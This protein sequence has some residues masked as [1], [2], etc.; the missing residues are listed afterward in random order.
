MSTDRESDI[1]DDSEAP[2]EHETEQAEDGAHPAGVYRIISIMGALALCALVPYVAPGL[3]RFR[4]WQ[5]GEEL[6]FTG[7]FSFEMP[8]AR[9]AIGGG[10][11]EVEAA[12]RSDDD[13]LSAA[14]LPE[15]MAPHG[16]GGASGDAG[17]T[18]A[19]RG[20]PAPRVPPAELQGLTREIELPAGGELDFFFERLAAA[21]RREPGAVAR[22]S[23]YAVSTNGADRVSSTIRQGLQEL[24][25]DAG[26][27]WIPIS[28][29]WT[30]QAHR[31]V[32][33]AYQSWRTAVVNRGRGPDGRYGLG[34]VIASSAGPHSWA[35]FGTMDDGPSNRAVSSFD[36]YYQSWPRGGEMVLEVDGAE[37]ERVNV[38][39]GEDT[40]D[41]VHEVRVPRGPH[42]L[43]IRVDGNVRLYG[44]TMENDGPGVVVDALMLIGASVSAAR[45]FDEEHI[46]TQVR[47]REPDLLVFWLGGND[48]ISRFFTP[49]RFRADYDD[50]IRR[51]RAGRPEASCLVVSVLDMGDLIDGRIRTRA[52]VEPVVRTQE[53]VARDQGCAF[54]NLYAATGGRGTVE[55]WYNA[56]TRLMV[57]DYVHLTDAGSRVVGTLI[58]R[59][60]LEAYDDWL[61]A[62]GHQ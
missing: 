5:P 23:M 57:A 19:P 53:Q 44:V 1:V 55:R 45:N 33:W 42:E 56:G 35:S 6:P 25:G 51:I 26:K 17:S 3:E 27:G 31:D 39:C 46:A 7:L 49:E 47:Q 12:A 11:G 13:L 59:A 18:P 48:V 43:T 38:H 34:G 54:F 10:S 28:P 24:F 60:I 41:L 21:A 58:R 22:I 2:P 40:R 52:Y 62:G 32:Q 30:Y 50:A 9:P 61:E 36:I 20:A 29:G 16:G 8:V 37:R 15:A 14:P 4:A